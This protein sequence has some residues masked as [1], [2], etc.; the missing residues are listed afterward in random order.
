MTLPSKI[1][2]KQT[3]GTT[4]FHPY[5]V[6]HVFLKTLVKHI[7]VAILQK[8]N[9]YYNL[10]NVSIFLLI[11]YIFSKVRLFGSRSKQGPL[12]G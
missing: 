7:I 9:T 4:M 10:V 12:I 1:I 6:H 3:M 2:M 5:I 8:M 11:S